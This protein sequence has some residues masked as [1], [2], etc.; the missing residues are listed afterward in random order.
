M[1]YNTSSINAM[2]ADPNPYRIG[3]SELDK[4]SEI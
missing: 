3:F 1:N 4:L 2:N